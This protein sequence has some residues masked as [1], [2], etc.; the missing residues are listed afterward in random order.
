MATEIE[1]FMKILR[2]N[3]AVYIFDVK[4]LAISGEPQP[5]RDKSSGPHR[6]LRLLA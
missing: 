2:K 4:K 1:N 6:W 5:D 3:V